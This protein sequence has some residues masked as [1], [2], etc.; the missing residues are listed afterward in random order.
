MPTITLA[1]LSFEYLLSL[2]NL[3]AKMLNANS[4]LWCH[5]EIIFCNDSKIGSLLLRFLGILQTTT[6]MLYDRA[7]VKYYSVLIK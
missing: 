6:C 7:S 3:F 2:L 4:D 1:I 5:P